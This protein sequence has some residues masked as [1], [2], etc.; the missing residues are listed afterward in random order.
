MFSYR[1]Y[2]AR[3]TS[4]AHQTFL[5][6]QEAQEEKKQRSNERREELAL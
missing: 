3:A 4:A 5:V 6:N 2:S 1:L